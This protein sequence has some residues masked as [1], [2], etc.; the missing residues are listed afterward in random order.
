MKKMVIYVI[1][2]DPIKSLT[3]WALQNDHQNLRFMKGNNVIG[4]IIARNTCKITNS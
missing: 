2:F 3:C 1:A 4:K